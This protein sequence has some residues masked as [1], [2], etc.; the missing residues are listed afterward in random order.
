M[1][2]SKL[3]RIKNEPFIIIL[4]KGRVDPSV[5]DFL[6]SFV[7]EVDHLLRNGYTNND[8]AY[9]FSI[10]HYILDA[11]A[12]AKIKCC[13]EHRGYCACEKCE[14]VGEWIDHCMTYVELDETLRTDESFRAGAILSPYGPLSIA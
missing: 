8:I 7:K 10:R 3:V 6:K 11:P 9:K 12:R 4:F 13:I 2:G 5:R 1:V 14:V